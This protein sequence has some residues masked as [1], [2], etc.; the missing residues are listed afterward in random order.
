M[1][2]SVGNMYT[3]TTEKHGISII[4]KFAFI[5]FRSSKQISSSSVSPNV[6][7]Y[8]AT[9]STNHILDP[10]EMPITKIIVDLIYTPTHTARFNPCK[11]ICMCVYK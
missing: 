10:A 6:S 3:Y 5:I 7:I 1:R 8:L 11:Y 2:L 4:T 9:T